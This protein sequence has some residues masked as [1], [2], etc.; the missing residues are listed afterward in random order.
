MQVDD[1]S[2]IKCI[3]K[4]AF[5]QVYLTTKNGSNKLYA[6]KIIPK[7]KVDSSSIKKHLL[8]EIEILKTLNHK[9]I[10]KFEAIKQNNDNYYIICEYYNGGGLYDILKQYKIIYGKPFPEIIVQHLMRQIIDAVI[11]LHQRKIIHRDLK[12]ENLLINYETEEDKNNLNLLNA[13]VKIIDFGFATHLDGSHL[14]YS[15]LGSPINMDPI[16]LTKLNNQNLSYLIGYDEKADIWSLG[17]VCYEMVTGEMLFPVLNVNQLV[18]RVEIG[19]YHIPTN[20]SQELVS[21]LDGMLQYLGK[22]RLSAI[23]LSSHPFLK[24]NVN[25]FSRIDLS[26][27][28]N[29]VDNL[30]LIVNIKRGNN[31]GFNSY[32][33]MKRLNINPNLIQ[34]NGNQNYLQ[35]YNYFGN[36]GPKYYVANLNRQNYGYQYKQT[37]LKNQYPNQYNALRHVHTYQ[38]PNKNYQ[39]VTK[40]NIQTRPNYQSNKQVNRLNNTNEKM[41]NIDNVENM[42]NNIYSQETINSNNKY[43]QNIEQN[44]FEYNNNN[45][46]TINLNNNLNSNPQNNLILNQTNIPLPDE[47]NISPDYPKQTQSFPKQKISSSFMKQ[48]DNNNFYN[49]FFPQSRMHNSFINK[50]KPIYNKKYFSNTDARKE[51]SSDALDNLFDFNIGK[52]LE[53]EPDINIDNLE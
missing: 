24:K 50:E 30:G 17:T 7:K 25:E 28:N 27:P 16:L 32:E 12:L 52:E 42:E 43:N 37:K 33:I 35:G 4:G 20:L 47:I 34:M 53:P 21:F 8:D 11:Y 23:E 40:I 38:Q 48:D 45:S 9:N 3:G 41:N 19:I 13:Q 26:N 5:G 36:T 10:I 29:K 2:L 6:T 1:F 18:Q 51:I 49:E 39:E 46:P 14:R 22:D 15:I 44:N 31:V